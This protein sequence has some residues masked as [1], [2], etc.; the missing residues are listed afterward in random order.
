MANEEQ[1]LEKVQTEAHKASEPHVHATQEKLE[2]AYGTMLERVKEQL[3]DVTKK[4][5]PVVDEVM[6][7]AKHKAVELGELTEEEAEKI[8]EYLL[9]DLR[10][11]GEFLK[12]AKRVLAD[13]IYFDYKLI[14]SK[15][16]DTYKVVSKQ[17]SAEWTEFSQRLKHTKEYRT[18]EVIGIGTLVC[19]ECGEV[20]HFTKSSTIPK[21]PKCS[22][23]Q[24]MRKKGK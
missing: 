23:T 2:K 19:R 1:E 18:G 17:V 21:C 22:G 5:E 4:T 9:R 13:W 12:D 7:K 8:G 10:D 11:A 16:W 24:F 6:E 3:N 14:E 20:L 15:F